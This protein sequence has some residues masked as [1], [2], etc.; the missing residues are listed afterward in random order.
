MARLTRL[1]RQIKQAG[2]ARRTKMRDR[3]R[4]MRRRSHS[5]GTWLRRRRDEA[6][7]EVLPITAAMTVIACRTLR[8]AVMLFVSRGG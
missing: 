3:T 7:S 5:I 1:G 2:L 8:E 6:N 4:S